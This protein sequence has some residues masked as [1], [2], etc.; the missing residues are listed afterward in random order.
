MRATFTCQK[1][2]LCDHTTGGGA[3]EMAIAPLTLSAGF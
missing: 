3:R 2:T 1:S